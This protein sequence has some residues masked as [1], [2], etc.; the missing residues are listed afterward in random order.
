EIGNARRD[1]R[2][3]RQA[4]LRLL[5]ALNARGDVL[6]VPVF[7]QAIADAD[8]DVVRV[9]RALDGEQ[10]V[11]ALVLLAD[12]HGLVGGAV[13]VFADLDLDQRALLLDHDDEVEPV[14][15]LL[16]LALAQRPRARDLV[17]ADAEIVALHLVEAELVERLADIEVA[18]AHRDDADLRR[19]PARD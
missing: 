11:A 9:E 7:E 5:Q 2:R 13:E 17:E 1:L 16:E 10:P 14:G 15:E 4:E 6:A 8:G 12:A 18:L 19:P 3:A